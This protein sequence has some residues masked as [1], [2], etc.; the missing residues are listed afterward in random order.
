MAPLACSQDF[1]QQD[2]AHVVPRGLW[3]VLQSEGYPCLWTGHKGKRA[4]GWSAAAREAPGMLCG[5]RAWGG[6]NPVLRKAG[7]PR[8]GVRSEGRHGPQE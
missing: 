4:A 1:W 3:H 2:P 5:F 6:A 8:G 7:G